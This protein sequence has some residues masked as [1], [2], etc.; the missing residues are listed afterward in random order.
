MKINWTVRIRN[1]TFWTTLIPAILLL[2]QVVLSVFGYNVT[3]DLFGDKLIS[4]VN[5]LFVVLTILGIVND[6]TTAGV[7]DSKQALTYTEPKKDAG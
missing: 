7:T 1:K 5:A 2:I 6:P 4:V 3:F